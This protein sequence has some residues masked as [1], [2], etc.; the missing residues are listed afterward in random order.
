MSVESARAFC[1]K[2]MSDDEFRD[3]LGQVESAD[4]I[5]DIIA[6]AGFS[7]NKFDLLKIVGELMGK[8][9]EAEELEGMVCGFYEE[10]VA[11]ENPKAVENVTEWFRSLE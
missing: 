8:K 10:E 6:N 2:M 7:F 11:A 1:M 5:R 4:G 3:S 9:I